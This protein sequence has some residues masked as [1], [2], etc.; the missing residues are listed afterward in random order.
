[1]FLNKRLK[2][3][4]HYETRPNEFK[5][6][7][8]LVVSGSHPGLEQPLPTTTA[9]GRAELIS[10]LESFIRTPQLSSFA[11]TNFTPPPPNRLMQ[12]LSQSA[13]FQI[14]KN[15]FHPA[16]KPRIKTLLRDFETMVVPNACTFTY[17]HLTGPVKSAKWIPRK[18]MVVCGGS[19]GS[20]HIWDRNTSHQFHHGARVWDVDVDCGGEVMASVG[21]NGYVKVSFLHF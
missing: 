6:L 7:C 1:M 15:R 12:L 9:S 10:C 4:E 11:P 19:E 21:G 14:L 18:R 13:S 17:R 2:P 3:L 16:T 8:Y 5:D 20:V